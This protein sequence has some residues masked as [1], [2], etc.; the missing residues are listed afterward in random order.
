MLRQSKFATY[1]IAKDGCVE[2]IIVNPVPSS[3]GL[4]AEPRILSLGVISR[5]LRTS[6]DRVIQRPRVAQMTGKFGYPYRAHH[7]RIVGNAASE[8]IF[9]FRN[10]AAFDHPGKAHVAASIKFLPFREQNRR[11]EADF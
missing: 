8:Q 5:C 6:C 7:R 11:V 4:M 9:Y 10:G 3:R 2:I 1:Y